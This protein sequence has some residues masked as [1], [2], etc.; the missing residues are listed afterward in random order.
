LRRWSGRFARRCAAGAVALVALA[1]VVALAASD[2][3]PPVPPPDRAEVLAARTPPRRPA[4]AST[5]GVAAGAGAPVLQTPVLEAELATPVAFPAAQPVV[6][7]LTAPAPPPPPAAPRAGNT[8]AERFPVQAFASQDA[9]DPASTRWA[10]LIGINEY[11]GRVSDNIGSRQ[12]AEDLR[13]HLLAQG[14][15]DQNILLLTDRAATRTNIVD[16]LRWLADKSDPSS[17]VVFHYSGHSKKWYGQDV[18][19]DGEVTD[20]GLWPTDDRF[21]VDS[22]LVRL[23]DPVDAGQAWFSF[24]TCNAAGFAD[25]GLARP[26][27]VLTFSSGEPQKSYEHPQWGNSVWGYLMIDE[28]LR[29]GKADTSR[30]G[31]VSVEEAWSWAR[32]HASY[33]TRGQRHGPQD[34]VI[35]DQLEGDLHLAV[36]RPSG[37]ARSP[38]PSAGRP[39][40]GPS[41]PA[42]QQPA[43]A[44]APEREEPERSGGYLCVLCG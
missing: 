10:L 19:G 39:P 12:D 11:M 27:R 3:D 28:A 26:G 35:I 44:P 25:R 8:F 17:T 38:E 16:G 9:A 36:P 42:P 34:A 13:A 32:P 24:A 20:E 33:T 18:D 6:A 21:I 41:R 7:P 30:D 40:A 37:A 1:P 23:L 14:W 2:A 15:R 4:A 29:A 31:R 5:S 22:E 43:P